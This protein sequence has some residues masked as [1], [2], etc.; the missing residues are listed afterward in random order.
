MINL[1]PIKKKLLKVDR[2][3]SIQDPPKLLAEFF[4]G[5]VIGVDEKYR[6]DS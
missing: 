6:Y 5:V 1:H 2:K 4:N 3:I